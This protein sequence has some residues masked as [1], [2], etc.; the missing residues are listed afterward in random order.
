MLN[1]DL[2]YF[3]YI[4]LFEK[5]GAGRYTCNINRGLWFFFCFVFFGGHI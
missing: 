2:C 5:A 4:N 3:T 1:Y